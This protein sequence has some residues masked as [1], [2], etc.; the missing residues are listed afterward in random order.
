ADE[1]FDSTFRTNVVVNNNGSCLY[2]PPGVFKSTCQIDITWFPFDDQKC[3]MKFGS[4]TYDGF[5]LDL[6]LAGNEEGKEEGDLTPFLPNGEWVLVGKKE[7]A[8]TH[9][10]LRSGEA[11]APILRLLS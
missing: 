4:W 2:V 1:K 5:S 8:Q 7:T 10:T 11:Y 6:D 9:S 3:V